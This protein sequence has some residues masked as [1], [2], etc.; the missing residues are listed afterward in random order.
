MARKIRGNMEIKNLIITL[1]LFLFERN[2]I[3]LVQT[4]AKLKVSNCNAILFIILV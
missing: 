4:I 2:L 1:K 3:H